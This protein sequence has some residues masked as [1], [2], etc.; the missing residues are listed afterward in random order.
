MKHLSLFGIQY[1]FKFKLKIIFFLFKTVV[2][3]QDH[4]TGFAALAANNRR[5]SEM[6]WVYL[7][8]NWKKIENIYGG[9]DSHLIYF[10]EVINKIIR[11][12]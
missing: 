12:I 10:I 8:K 5:G 6:C 1:G 3:K 9:H 4:L 7:Q 2:R 11:F